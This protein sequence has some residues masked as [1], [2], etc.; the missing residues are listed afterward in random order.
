MSSTYVVLEERAD[1]GLS[2][3]RLYDM[4]RMLCGASSFPQNPNDRFATRDAADANAELLRADNARSVEAT[5]RRRK[6]KTEPA[7]Y[8]VVECTPEN[9]AAIR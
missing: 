8:A 2:Y 1:G 9:E 6:Y 7:T 4:S 3:V 5:R